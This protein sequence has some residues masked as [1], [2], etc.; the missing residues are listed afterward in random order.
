MTLQRRM[1]FICFLIVGHAIVPIDFQCR[2]QAPFE[3]EREGLRTTKVLGDCVERIL[4]TL[5][6]ELRNTDLETAI[7]AVRSRILIL[8]GE[9]PQAFDLRVG[10][11]SF[12]GTTDT[13]EWHRL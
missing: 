1:H 13:N 6:A 9:N 10:N 4:K 8:A 5:A 7:E 3:V 2:S 11:I 12:S